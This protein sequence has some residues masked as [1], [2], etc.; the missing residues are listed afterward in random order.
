MQLHLNPPIPWEAGWVSSTNFQ[1]RLA[2]GPRML[3]PLCAC[4][5]PMRPHLHLWGQPVSPVDAKLIHRY[6]TLGQHMLWHLHMCHTYT[7]K[8]AEL[9]SWLHPCH[10]QLFNSTHAEFFHA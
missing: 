7:P 3:L 8:P 2:L 6:T 5:T 1:F 10:M 9:C 4:V